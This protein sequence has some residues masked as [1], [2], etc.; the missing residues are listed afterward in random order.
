M[1]QE[2]IFPGQPWL[3]TNGN[4]IQAHGG[5]VYYE[6]GTYYWYGENKEH[7]DGVSDVWTWGIKVYS[8][9]D[10]CNWQDEGYLVEPDVNDPS[11]PLHP[12]KRVDR[13][14]LLRCPQTGRYV[15]WLKLSGKD[16]CFAVLSS[17]RLLGP[18]RM[19]NPC[20]RP[21]GGEA[22]DFDIVQDSASGKA[23]LYVSINH[24]DV[25]GYALT[26][27]DLNVQGEVSRQYVGLHS[28]FTRE[29]IAVFE[30]E[31]KNFMLTS[32]MSG[33]IPN[34]S[35]SAVSDSWETPFVSLGNPHVIDDSRASFNSQI[36]KVFRVEG[37]DQLIAMA[38]RWVPD[39]PVDARR[40]DMFERAIASHYEPEKYHVLPQEK[41]ELM[42]S[43]MLKS[44]NTSKALY[45]WLPIRWE[46]DKPK[47]DW[48]DCWQP[49]H[50]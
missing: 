50:P 24:S 18:Y 44:A 9:R 25:V 5:A 32:G 22:G 43:P 28:P 38:D 37:T 40:A 17:E 10:L 36:S 39:Y 1:R 20:L 49:Q 41:L 42:N 13:P 31:G 29:G 8:S 47:I 23:Y 45:V 14:H 12:A 35:D 16:A 7:T 19:E 21:E 4:A 26:A 27:D 6:D 15:L 34:K 2:S 30:H 33:Y 46:G 48:L 11:S 3:D